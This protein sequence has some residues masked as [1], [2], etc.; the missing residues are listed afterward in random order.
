MVD[1]IGGDERDELSI[2]RVL[3]PV[4]RAVPT[5]DLLDL[6]GLEVRRVDVRLP[7]RGLGVLRAQRRERDPLAVGREVRR[8][9]V[10]VT[11]R[12]LTRRAAVSRNDEDV[13]DRFI[14][15]ADTV[16]AIVEAAHDLRRLDPL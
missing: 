14:G 6:A 1:G 11:G 2:W 4:A 3:R 8:G 9:G 12:D 7:E 13:A 10:P 15:E 16:G 5:R